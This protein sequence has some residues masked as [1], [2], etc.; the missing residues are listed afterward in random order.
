MKM[1]N[2][3]EFITREAFDLA[4]AEDGAPKDY[5]YDEYVRDCTESAEDCIERLTGTIEQL[6]HRIEILYGAHVMIEI[7]MKSVIELRDIAVREN[8]VLRALLGSRKEG[9]VH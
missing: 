6:E 3:E 7:G 4:L 2:G 8:E 9:G 1:V 5:T